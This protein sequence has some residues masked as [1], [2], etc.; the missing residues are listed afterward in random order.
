[1][2]GFSEGP[3][4]YWHEGSGYKARTT[5]DSRP[6]TSIDDRHLK[7]SWKGCS[8]EPKHEGWIGAYWCD[9]GAWQRKM[10]LTSNANLVISNINLHETSALCMVRPARLMKITTS[11]PNAQTKNEGCIGKRLWTTAKGRE[12]FYQPH[13]YYMNIT[14][15]EDTDENENPHWINA[16]FYRQEKQGR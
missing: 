12:E 7:S 16:V 13:M 14:S 8:T 15:N 10:A 3:N 1:M 9:E 2:S 11:S 5:E 4:C 6:Q